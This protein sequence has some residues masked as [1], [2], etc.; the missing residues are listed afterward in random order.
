MMKLC[1]IFINPDGTVRVM[2][3]NMKYWDAS[4]E[5]EEE[6]CRRV[7]DE[8]MRKDASLHGLPYQD[9]PIEDIR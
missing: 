4:E 2:Y 3:P 1:R 9:T 7:C 6:F 8:D 5:K